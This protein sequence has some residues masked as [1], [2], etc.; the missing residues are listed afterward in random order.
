MQWAS[1]WHD[2]MRLLS[3]SASRIVLD[4]V[5]RLGWHFKALEGWVAAVQHTATTDPSG[6]SPYCIAIAVGLTG[7][8]PLCS[9]I[10]LGLLPH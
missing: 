8:T 5:V 2:P 7:A 3:H 9:L 1:T 4:D 10:E 6:G